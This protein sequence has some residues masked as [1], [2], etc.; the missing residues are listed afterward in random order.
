MYGKISRSAA[1]PE[2]LNE[3]GVIASPSQT[4]WL[5]GP[6]TSSISSIGLTITVVVSESRVQVAVVVLS[7]EIAEK[8]AEPDA[9]PVV[10]FIA[11]PATLPRISIVP[12]W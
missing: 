12:F 6:E 7:I 10:I 2:A 8:E 9:V 11:V 3:T 1:P 4:T 5:R